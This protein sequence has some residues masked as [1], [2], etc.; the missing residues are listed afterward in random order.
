ML[1]TA[2]LAEAQAV[3]QHPGH[4]NGNCGSYKLHGIAVFL[5]VKL[6]TQPHLNL[7]ECV[8]IGVCSL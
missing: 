5:H 2:H 6:F 8:R 4:G 3:N 7:F 1:T